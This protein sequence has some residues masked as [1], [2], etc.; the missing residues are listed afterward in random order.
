MAASRGLHSVS[1]IF[2]NL[3]HPALR[4]CQLLNIETISQVQSVRLFQPSR[5]VTKEMLLPS[6]TTFSRRRENTN[7]SIPKTNGRVNRVFAY[8]SR[9]VNL[10]N[11]TTFHLANGNVVSK[12]S[13][14]RVVLESR[15]LPRY[16]CC[17]LLFWL[18]SDICMHLWLL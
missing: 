3:F 13:A 14:S 7:V 1:T 16:L 6:R 12:K 4:R 5:L 8:F 18:M 2:E 10:V 9:C 15:I 17:I 11:T